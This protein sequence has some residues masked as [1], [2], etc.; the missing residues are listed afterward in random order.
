VEDYQEQ[1]YEF[2]RRL[3]EESLDRR[4]L[5][6]RGLAAGAGLTIF[7]LSDV[8][9][10]T[11]A[12]VLADPPVRGTKAS[13]KEMVAEAKKEGHLND[14]ALPDDWA[15]YGEIIKTFGKRY[16]TQFS[17]TNPSGTSAQENQ[18]IV[19]LK[20]DP[21]APDVVDVGPSFAV[22]GAAAGLYAR[23]FVS[24][25]KTVPRA[26]KDTRGF[27]TGDYW[28]AISIG[29]NANIISTPPKTF[30]DLL[31]PAYHKKVALNGSP[32]QSNSAVAGVL[33]ASLANGGS[34]NNVGPGIDW[35]AKCNSVGN[36]IPIQTTPQTVASG[37]TPIS[38]D[39]DYNNLVYITE[40]PAAKWRVNIPS[41]GVY[42]GYYSQAINATAP[43]P[44]TARLWEEFLYSDQGQI[45][46]LKG[47][48]HPARFTD[49]AGRK[50]IPKKLLNALPAAAIYNKVRFASLSQISK[51]AAQCK[52]EWP[53]KVGS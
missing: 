39:W 47:F 29:Y 40:F 10:A 23:Y 37:Q 12:R 21:R 14:I 41:D 8:A 51:A 13:M 16:G 28:G 24:N 20:G 50:V 30:A 38:I 11:R 44:W 2:W 42:G 49:L 48:A 52:A 5:L 26:M 53:A 22:D 7:S 45:L 17:R 25:Y 46:Y 4:K 31:K 6:R 15:N 18:A 34:L 19:S 33:A 9:L 3:E 35:F 32:T 27:W 36:F 43:H 1:E